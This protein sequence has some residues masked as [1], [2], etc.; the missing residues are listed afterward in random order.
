[1]V[2]LVGAA[3]GAVPALFIQSIFVG[4]AQRCSELLERVAAGAQEETVCA[5]L[6]KN[7]A[8]WLPP[9]IATGGAAIGIIGGFAYGFATPKPTVNKRGV[10]ER[11][12]LPF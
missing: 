6:F 11:P 8:V 3:L 12:W 2:G 9:A 5:D 1:M 4:E 7:P 10:T